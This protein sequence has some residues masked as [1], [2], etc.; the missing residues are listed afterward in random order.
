MDNVINEKIAAVVVTYNRKELLGE[1]LDALLH[2]TRRLDTIIVVDNASTDGTEDF[3]RQNY[4]DNEIFC[5]IHLPENTGGAG[6]FHEGMKQAYE[7]GYDWIWVMDDDVV[8]QEDAL[9]H[10]LKPELLQ[11]DDIYALASAVLTHDGNIDPFHR[12]SFDLTNVRE[13]PIAIEYYDTECFETDTVTFVGTFVSRK[14]V[15]KIGLP[16]K[17]FFIY[18]DDTEYSLRMRTCGGRIL[19]LPKSRVLHKAAREEM[20]QIEKRHAP[21][22]WRDFYSTRNKLYTYR[23]YAN[24]GWKFYVKLLGRSV[25]S[26]VD[27]IRFRHR[28]LASTRFLWLSLLHGIKGKLGKTFSP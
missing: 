5:Y 20:R 14:A 1:C 2:Q 28:K 3:L 10:L 22:S 19:T 13:Q 6:G 15:A 7:K 11:C 21:L 17:D 23:K 8:P 16:I 25:L 26:Q 24:I 9:E 12:R 18:Y 4:L 27:I